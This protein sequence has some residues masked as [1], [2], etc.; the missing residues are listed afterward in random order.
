M[1]VLFLTLF[2]TV[3]SSV[4]GQVDS[5]HDDIIVCLTINGTPQE[6]NW[7]Y[8]ESMGVLYQQFKSSDAPEAFWTELKSDKDEKVDELL[9][10]LAFAY[11]N[12]FS[13][14]DVKG[15]TEFYKTDTAQ[16]MLKD[17]NALSEDQ[18]CEIIDFEN[19]EIGQKIATEQKELSK[20]MA[21]IVRDWK[22]E[23]FSEK[24]KK[25]I[26]NGYRPQY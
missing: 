15:I 19:T 4:F 10:M 21:V 2:L 1:R 7:E 9:S 24:M 20:E 6:Y 12:H 5:F 8:D 16:L 14:E 18:K 23:L 11:R 13:K 3:Y 26:K 25:L 17:Y 22:T